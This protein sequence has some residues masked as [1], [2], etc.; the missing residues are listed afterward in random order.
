MDESIFIGE[1]PY[2]NAKGLLPGRSIHRKKKYNFEEQVVERQHHCLVLM[3]AIVSECL[4]SL[5]MLCNSVINN[6]KL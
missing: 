6:N 2:P 5:G 3:F 1:Y 4:S